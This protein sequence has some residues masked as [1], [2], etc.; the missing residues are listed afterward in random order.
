MKRGPY[1][2]LSVWMKSLELSSWIYHVTRGYPAE[3]MNGLTAKTRDCALSIPSHIAEGHAKTLPKY[4]IDKF[5]DGVSSLYMLE[6]NVY[7][8]FTQGYIE[9][10]VLDEALLKIKLLKQQL[11]L[12]IEDYKLGLGKR[13]VLDNKASNI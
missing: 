1:T 11:N 10:A 7:L 8:A 4:A 9:K 3:E 2:E 6:T 13:P 5:Y 12:F